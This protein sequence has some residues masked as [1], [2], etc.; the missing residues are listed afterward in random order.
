MQILGL[1]VAASSETR[2]SFSFLL[3][4][5]F[6]FLL[7]P[8]AS[9]LVPHKYEPEDFAVFSQVFR[10]PSPIACM[11]R[12][13]Q[14]QDSPGL[15][16]IFNLPPVCP[17]YSDIPSPDACLPFTLT[18]FKMGVVIGSREVPSVRTGASSTR[19]QHRPFA[20]ARCKHV[21]TTPP[22]P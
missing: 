4:F 9:P 12:F 15:I 8:Q 10:P 6:L 18:F 19:V 20:E 21:R 17:R 2:I 3:R 14:N 22:F 11:A 16:L 13:V 5:P 1:T 7:L